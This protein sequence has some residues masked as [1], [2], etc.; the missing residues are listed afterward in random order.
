[1]ELA[2]RGARLVLVCRDRQRG[3]D[4]VE[5]IRRGSGEAASDF[6]G[7]RRVIPVSYFQTSP[8]SR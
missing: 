3:E 7:R 6:L 2:R 8:A 1:M 4:A 5:E